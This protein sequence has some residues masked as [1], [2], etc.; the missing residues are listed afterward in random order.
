MKINYL[1]TNSDSYNLIEKNIKEYNINCEFSE[2]PGYLFSQDKKQ[3]KELE[4]IFEASKK[5]GC[6]V[7]YS[8]SIPVSVE[9]NKAVIFKKQ[10]QFH[11]TK[12][13]YVLA[14]AFED[15]GGTLVQGCRITGVNENSPL[16]MESDRGKIIA[17]SLIYATHVPVSYTH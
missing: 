4:D 15:A 17:R 13:L 7:V 8:E 9:F 12:Y 1:I 6:D 11:P 5:A 3:S 10:A 16:E 14:K 2:Q